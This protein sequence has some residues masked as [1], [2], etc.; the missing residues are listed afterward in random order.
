MKIRIGNANVKFFG[1][2]FYLHVHRLH[3]NQLNNN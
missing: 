2:N 1:N 3:E